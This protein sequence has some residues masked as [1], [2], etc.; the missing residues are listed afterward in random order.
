MVARGGIYGGLYGDGREVAS[1]AKADT[2]VCTCHPD[3]APV[4]C[5]RKYATHDCWRAAVLDETQTN[6]AYLKGRD[7]DQRE[8]AWL[9]YLMR[10]RRAVEFY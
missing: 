7:R 5:P 3:D 6:I 10:V 8:Q 4:P 1:E 9:D 2:R